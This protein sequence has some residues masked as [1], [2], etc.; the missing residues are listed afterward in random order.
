MAHFDR[1]IWPTWEPF[2]CPLSSREWFLLPP[3]QRPPKTERLGT[4]LDDV[5]AIR[6]AIRQRLRQARIRKHGGPFR[7]RQVRRDD[8]RRSFGAI[9]D[10][11]L[12]TCKL[13]RVAR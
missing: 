8:D 5:R 9:R 6:N 7:E 4:R 12:R 13:T 1:L 2:Y 10:P 11:R 3:L